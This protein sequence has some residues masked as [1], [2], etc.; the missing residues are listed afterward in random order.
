MLDQLN[1][2]SAFASLVVIE[3]GSSDATNSVGKSLTL[4][5]FFMSVKIGCNVGTKIPYHFDGYLFKTHLV[6]CPKQ[7]SACHVVFCYTFYAVAVVNNVRGTRRKLAALPHPPP[8]P[9]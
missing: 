8:A 6:V 1:A 3:T 7:E 4:G 2:A 9:T 5:G